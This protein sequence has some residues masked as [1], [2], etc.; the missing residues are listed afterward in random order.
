VPEIVALDEPPPL[1][2]LVL[3]TLLSTGLSYVKAKL[4]VPTRMHT[5]SWIDAVHTPALGVAL[6]E[7][8][9][10]QIVCVAAVKPT[11]AFWDMWLT[12]KLFPVTVMNPK[13]PAVAP[14]EIAKLET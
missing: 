14:F 11:T 3:L 6:T 9:D 8:S 10:P 5:V 12:A 2:A 13:M 1:G 7:E 4:S